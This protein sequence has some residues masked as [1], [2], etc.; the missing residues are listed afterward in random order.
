MTQTALTKGAHH[1]G[2]TVPDLD[3]AT[4][5]FRDALG[6]AVVGEVPDY[7]AR[8]VSDG[9]TLLTLWQAKDPAKAARFDRHRNV[10]LHH[11][12]LAVTDRA[13]LDRVHGR[14]ADWPGVE[15]EFGPG[16]M[17]PGSSVDHLIAAIPGGIR[18][19]FAMPFA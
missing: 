6:F 4:A 3:Q 7:P 1:I 15:L 5:F 17:R 16:P 12:A 18:V 9:T 11:L 19:E 2:L 10:G 13:A 14:I 8:F